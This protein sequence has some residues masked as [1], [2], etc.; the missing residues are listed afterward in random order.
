[1]RRT[2]VATL[3][4][5]WLGFTPGPVRADAARWPGSGA[6][7]RVGTAVGFSQLGEQNVTTLGGEVAIGYRLGL[8]VL[9]AQYSGLSM[10]EYIEERGGNSHRG[11]LARYGVAGRFFFATL[12]RPGE[13]DPDSVFRLYL[14]LGAGRQH[15][16]WSSGDSFARNDVALGAG[17]LLEHRV[18]PRPG[19][20]PLSSVG[21]H[22]GWQLDT[23]RTDRVE[24]ATER[25]TCKSCGPPMPGARDLDASLMVSCALV[26]TW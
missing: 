5:V 1:M 8:L 13:I 25:T 3:A 19:G 20:L 14:E 2:S 12:S 23:S 6:T 24:L 17:W 11:E 10:L 16:R 21:W 7:A 4:V 18:R 22:F 26:A 15:G 9:E